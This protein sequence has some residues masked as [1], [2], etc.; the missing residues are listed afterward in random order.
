MNTIMDKTK[1]YAIKL[2]IAIMILILY[3]QIVAKDVKHATL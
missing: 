1:Q 2:G 3:V